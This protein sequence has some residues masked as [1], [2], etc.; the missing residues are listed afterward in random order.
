LAAL[1][2]AA[3]NVAAAARDM[4]I[5]ET[6]VKSRVKM[7]LRDGDLTEDDLRS[8]RRVPEVVAAATRLPQT[9]DECWAVLDAAMGRSARTVTQPKPPRSRFSDQ[10]IVIGSDLHCPF[11]DVAAVG[12]MFAETKGYDA[13]KINGDLSDSYSLSRFIKYEHVGIEREIAAI[14]SVLGTA[15]TL[16][17]RVDVSDGNHDAARFE[18][19]I[20]T[21]LSL[22]QMHV[23]EYLTGGNLSLI[24]AVAKRYANVHF[25]KVQVG[26]HSLGWFQQEGDLLMSHAEAFSKVPGS[27]LRLV[28]EWFSDRHDTLGLQ[29]WKVLIQAHTHQMAWIPWHADRLLIE[30][31]C[32][33][34]T[35]GYQLTA[36]IAGRPQRV[37]YVTLNQRDGVTD[38]GSI[39]LHWIDAARK[40]A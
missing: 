2:A 35:H 23:I 34:E 11:Q 5:S 28:E 12:Q 24:R 37:G 17:A 8:W 21:Q 27:T 13:L 31:G 32:L 40:A 4:G 6:T 39:R 19:A 33:C 20:R 29:P 7:L 22:D 25:P 26:R 9:A 38:I 16:Y 36:R 15:S 1:R 10:R 14:D 30:S 18:K 3:G